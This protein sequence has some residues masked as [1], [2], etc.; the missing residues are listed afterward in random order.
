MNP[1]KATG[2]IA[3]LALLSLAGGALACGGNPMPEARTSNPALG[4]EMKAT[5]RV[6]HPGA[7][8][9]QVNRARYGSIMGDWYAVVTLTVNGSKLKPTIFARHHRNHHTGPW[10]LARQTRGA[11]CGRYIPVPLIQVWHLQRVHH[12]DCFVEPGTRL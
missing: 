6:A 4:A 10:Y 8:S 1:R 3:V 5:Y 7:R 12:T 11:V 9:V 2:T